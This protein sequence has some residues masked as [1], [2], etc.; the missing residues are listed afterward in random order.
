M[1]YSLFKRL[2]ARA[3][4]VCARSMGVAHLSYYACV[5]Y[6]A[7]SFYGWIAGG[8]FVLTVMVHGLQA[9]SGIMDE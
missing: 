4:G 8:L 5:A 2:T 6:E 3:H 1:K 9:I 7:H